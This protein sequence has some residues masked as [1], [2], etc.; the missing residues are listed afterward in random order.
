MSE[1]NM[2]EQKT[3]Y[4]VRGNV[5]ILNKELSMLVRNDGRECI[6]CTAKPFGSGRRERSRIGGGAEGDRRLFSSTGN[7]C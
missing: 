5:I 1:Q 7:T 6:Y 4:Q 3:Y 2:N